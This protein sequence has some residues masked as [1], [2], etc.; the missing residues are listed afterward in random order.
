LLQ[1]SQIAAD[2][3]SRHL[4]SVAQLR[5]G[6]G[7]L[8]AKDFADLEATLFSKHSECPEKKSLYPKAAGIKASKP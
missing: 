8:R 2:G 3:R 7:P 1:S 5:G 4:Q 6:Y